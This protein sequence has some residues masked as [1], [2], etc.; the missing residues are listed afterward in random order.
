M[1]DADE[2]RQQSRGRRQAG[3]PMGLISREELKTKLDTQQDIKLVMV[4]GP[5]EFR[6]KHLPRSLGFPRPEYAL[7]ELQRDDEI[8]VYANDHHRI[9]TAVA[10]Q[11]LRAHGYRNVRCYLGG[12]ADWEAAGYPVEGDAVDAK[13][14]W[15]HGHSPRGSELHGACPHCD[16]GWSGT[17]WKRHD[18]PKAD[19]EDDD[20]SQRA[21][22]RL[23]LARQPA[24]VPGCV[25]SAIRDPRTSLVNRREVNGK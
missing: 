22:P 17:G 4:V 9:N 19:H 3:R 23:Q 1:V 18:R 10:Y 20:H 14:R 24:S 8:I 16:N 11:A 13:H 21:K 25:G 6:T 12:V 15:P 2:R 5:W 7:R